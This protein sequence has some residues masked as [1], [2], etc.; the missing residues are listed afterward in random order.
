MLAPEELELQVVLI[1]VVDQMAMTLTLVEHQV[2]Y[3]FAQPVEV[4]VEVELLHREVGVHLAALIIKILQA[5]AQLLV[6]QETLL[7]L[8]VHQ[9]H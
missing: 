9:V 5:V 7:E 2:R 3:L 4:L 1:L 6:Q 8:L